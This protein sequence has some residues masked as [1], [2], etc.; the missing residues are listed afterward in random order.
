MNGIPS[1]RS[2]VEKEFRRMES[3]GFWRGVGFVSCT[4]RVVYFVPTFLND[5]ALEYT[6]LGS[7]V[8]TTLVG[9][10]LARNLPPYQSVFLIPDDLHI[11]VIV[12]NEDGKAAALGKASLLA[13]RSLRLVVRITKQW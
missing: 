9:K 10:V 5:N 6:S 8:V 1:G 7:A 4:L 12:A 11:F 2:V 13:S 3:K